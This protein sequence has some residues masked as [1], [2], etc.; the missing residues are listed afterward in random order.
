MS[1]K[2]CRKA[3]QTAASALASNSQRCMLHALQQCLTSVQG[4]SLAGMSQLVHHEIM[5]SLIV[6]VTENALSNHCCSHLLALMKHW[7]M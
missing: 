4:L 6:I 3:S 5:N 2:F 7:G 1:T